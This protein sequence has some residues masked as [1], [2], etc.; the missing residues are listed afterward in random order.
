VGLIHPTR[1]ETVLNGIR[2]KRDQHLRAVV[3]LIQDQ[4][5]ENMGLQAEIFQLE[6]E[7][8]KLEVELDEAHKATAISMQSD[9]RRD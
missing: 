2:W 9:D 5:A 4:A 6:Q 1:I 7:I 8:E 3:Q